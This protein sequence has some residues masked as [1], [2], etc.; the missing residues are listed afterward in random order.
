[1]PRRYRSRKRIGHAVRSLTPVDPWCH[2]PSRFSQAIME[3]HDFL[4]ELHDRTIQLRQPFTWA[5]IAYSCARLATKH[6]SYRD[7]PLLSVVTSEI[8]RRVLARVGGLPGEPGFSREQLIQM[9]ERLREFEGSL[10]A[11]AL[12]QDR[13]LR[14]IASGEASPTDWTL[15]LLWD[16][17]SENRLTPGHFD[18]TAQWYSRSVSQIDAVPYTGWQQELD[19]MVGLAEIKLEIKRLRNFLQVQRARQQRGLPVR[20]IS[21]HQVF[22]GSP[23]TGK[24][25]VARILAKVYREFGF[26]AKGHLVETDRS[27][28]VG[29]VIGATEAKTEEAIRMAIGGV[30]FID[31]AY[32]LATESQQDFGQRAIDTLVKSMED[33]RGQLVIIVAGYQSQMER[34]LTANPGL[35]SRFNRDLHFPDY[36]SDELLE[37][38]KRLALQDHFTL[39]QNVSLR[40]TTALD[41]RRLRLGERFGNAR[42]VRTLWET[43]LMHHA[44]RLC[45]RHGD[46]FTN[47]ELLRLKADDVPIQF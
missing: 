47:E 25:S 5:H 17:L 32:S 41:S 18:G 20:R 15:P 8:R 22:F 29:T 38:F 12:L 9:S 34:F 28:L 7:E 37:V 13:F 11:P 16:I 10:Q 43:S 19:E 4:I 30:L 23:G 42:D 3:P 27:G 14:W 31:E 40:V 6:S 24:T 36:T 39:D 26:L 45:E 35:A 2:H 1:M 21:L 46:E 33:L 44:S